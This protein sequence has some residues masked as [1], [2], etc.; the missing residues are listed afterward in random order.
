V[1]DSEP[2]RGRPRDP[3]TQHDI[4]AA[5][6]ALLTR[7]GYDQV[8]I[9]AIARAAGVSRP[10]VYR[11]WPSKAHV[12]F[13]A[14][15]GSPGDYGDNTGSGDFTADLREFVSG[16]IRFWTEPTVQ[17]AALGI[18]AD[19]ARDPAL[20]IRTQQLLDQQTQNAFGALARRG[21]ADGQ[22]R[23]DLEV[24]LLYETLIGTTFYAVQVQHRDD[25]DTIVGQ[26]CSL[27]LRGAERKDAP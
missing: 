15:F 7:D 18:L 6:R 16:A 4:M 17:A 27:V 14:V 21:I 11:R 9:D 8:S 25:V 23:A 13:E 2:A 24:D 19:R 5:T 20:H 22:L 10:T 1:S 3:R 12:V 26:L